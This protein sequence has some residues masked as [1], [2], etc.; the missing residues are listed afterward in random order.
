VETRFKPEN[1]N[2][3]NN[4]NKTRLSIYLVYLFFRRHRHRGLVETNKREEQE[5]DGRRQTHIEGRREKKDF[6]HLRQQLIVLWFECLT[7]R[8]WK[9][10]G[11][12]FVS[13]VNYQH[14]KKRTQ[15]QHLV[16][17]TC[18][19]ETLFSRRLYDF[20]ACLLPMLIVTAR[21]SFFC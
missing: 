9:R 20:D 19:Y 14:K 2:Y 16:K 1:A 17:R 8:N 4:S 13:A 3:N 12:M 6:L 10:R 18:M 7:K 11:F 21:P 5:K 15:E